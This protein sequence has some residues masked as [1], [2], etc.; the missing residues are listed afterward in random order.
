MSNSFSYEENEQILETY[1]EECRNRI[2][3]T[4]F[5]DEEIKQG[6]SIKR[7]LVNQGVLTNDIKIEDAIKTHRNNLIDIKL[8]HTMRVV[9]DV[10]KMAEKMDLDIDFTKVLKVSALLHDIA[11]FDQATWANSFQDRECKQFN[12]MYH[13][14]FGY[15]I[16]YVN[17]RINDFK[18]PE[19][20]KF[21][22]MQPVKY[23]QIPNVTGDLALKFTNKNELD[24]NKI[25]TGSE[26]LNEAE[27]IIVA[28]LVQMVKDVDMLDILYQH[29]TNEFP[30]TRPYVTYDI[31]NSNIKEISKYW[32]VSEK[33]ILEYNGLTESFIEGKKSIKVP[34]SSIEP[35]KLEIP[36]DIKKMFFAN[37]D[38]NLKELQARNDYTFITGMWWRLNHFLNNI[39]FVSNLEVIEENKLLDN[40]FATYPDVYKKLVEPAFTFAKEVLIKKTIKLNQDNIY[41]NERPK[42]L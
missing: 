13:A 40:I 14:D 27:K 39:N 21:A 22:V 16:L 15:H 24:V 9:K 36:E 23:H 5:T 6:V 30:V 11:R 29:L 12:G 32:G 42:S 35:S 10:T 2:K 37:I 31:E 1:I 17:K 19:N 20:F 8:N 3:N 7:D 4:F 33:E 26:N 25:L 18:I 38:M 34:A 41:V 28:T